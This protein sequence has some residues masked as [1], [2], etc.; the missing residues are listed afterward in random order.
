MHAIQLLD[1]ISIIIMCYINKMP[2][3]IRG[4]IV[5]SNVEIFIEFIFISSAGC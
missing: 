4:P 5:Y 2:P 3:K 1:I